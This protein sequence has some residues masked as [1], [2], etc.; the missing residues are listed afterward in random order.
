[1]KQRLARRN[2]RRFAYKL[3]LGEERVLDENGLFTGEYASQY[4][5][6]RYGYANINSGYISAN[7][8]SGST[9]TFGYG[10]MIDYDKILMAS[11]TFGIDEFSL[12]WL[13]DLE[14]EG[15]EYI[16]KRVGQS[17]GHVRIACAHVEVNADGD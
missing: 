3:Y 17:K 15:N 14:K 2:K 1:M 8:M 5:E 16:V 11:S 7:H 9:G 12:I 13:D 10:I 6:K 4:T